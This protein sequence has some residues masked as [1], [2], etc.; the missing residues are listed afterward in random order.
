MRWELHGMCLAVQVSK[1]SGGHLSGVIKHVL[2]QA[3]V[4]NVERTKLPQGV[5]KLATKHS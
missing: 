3:F 5:Y 4:L 2:H 1:A